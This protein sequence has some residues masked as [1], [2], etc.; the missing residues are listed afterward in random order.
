MSDPV[1]NKN[2]LETDV[3]MKSIY[4]D[5][6]F[7]CRGDAITPGS[8]TELASDIATNPGGLMQRII[9]QPYTHEVKKEIKYR[10]VAGHRRYAACKML[11]WTTIPSVIIFGLSLEDAEVMNLTENLK[12]KDLNMLQEARALDKMQAKG[13][14]PAQIAKRL[15]MGTRWVTE[16]LLL[17]QLP[18][19]VQQEAAAGIIKAAHIQELVKLSKLSLD[20]MYEGVRNIKNANGR[21]KIIVKVQNTQAATKKRE[22]RNM[23]DVFKMQDC[24]VD[25]I[26]TNLGSRALAWAIGEISTL[27][28]LADVK[29]EADLLG[30]PWSVPSEYI[31]ADRLEKKQEAMRMKLETVEVDANNAE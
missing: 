2:K 18:E 14:S 16:R 1:E 31:E 13:L 24:I 8:V 20:R 17:L 23:S 6:E 25:G 7:N 3:D 29:R 30:L 12:R 26:G 21:R 22:F 28:F 9:I 15:D 27:E 4:S 19:D 10:I 11:K 5:S